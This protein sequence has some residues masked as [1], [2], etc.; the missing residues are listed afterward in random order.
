MFKIIRY[1]IVMFLL[2]CMIFTDF[3]KFLKKK[4]DSLPSY[5][6][7]EEE[8][9]SEVSIHRKHSMYTVH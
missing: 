4:I 9:L 8:F 1:C 6:L 2:V 7:N 5:Y 3:K